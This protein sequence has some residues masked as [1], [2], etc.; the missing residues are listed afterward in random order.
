MK[1]NWMMNDFE[2]V[3]V[4]NGEFPAHPIPLAFW[5]GRLVW[6]AAMVGRMHW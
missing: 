5:T 2:A 4:G 3:V 6:S 1:K